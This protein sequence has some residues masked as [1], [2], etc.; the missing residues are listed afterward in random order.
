MKAR[1]GRLVLTAA[2]FIGWLSYLGYLVLCRP[3]T[4][5]GLG[6]ALT[7][8]PITLCRPQF[9]VSML[10]LV[11]QVNDDKGEDV[12]VEEVLFPQ[13]NAPVQPAARIH[14]EDI[15]KCRPLRDA[16]AKDREKATDFNGPG[17]YLLPLRVIENKGEK[18]YR[19]V[20]TP[21]SPGYPPLH[22]ASV[23]PPR[24]YPANMKTLAEYR[25]IDKGE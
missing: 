22:G 4:P 23:G 3:H 25:E 10:D 16:E 21:P 6:G 7:G 1:V 24:I 15:D 17:R 18:H 8:R 9:L 20:P 2:L 5:G 13:K 12:V 19:V 14:V 11:A